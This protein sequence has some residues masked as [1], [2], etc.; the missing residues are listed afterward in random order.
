MQ[1]A[2][3]LAVAGFTSS[4]YLCSFEGHRM[5]ISNIFVEVLVTVNC[6]E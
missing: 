2:E 4:K 1:T 5:A 3:T 6:A